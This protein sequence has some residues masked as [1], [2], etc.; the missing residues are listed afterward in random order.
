LNLIRVLGGHARA[1]DGI[2]D[3]GI[4]ADDEERRTFGGGEGAPV[5]EP[6][7][8]RR[9]AVGFVQKPYRIAELSRTVAEK[10]RPAR[11]R[12]SA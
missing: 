1:G 6:K 4:P 9:G 11:V 2:A 12:S 10:M 7:L 5:V 8:L 3:A